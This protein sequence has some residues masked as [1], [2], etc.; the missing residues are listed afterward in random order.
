M[1]EQRPGES[2]DTGSPL[3]GVAQTWEWLANAE[4]AETQAPDAGASAVG[5]PDAGDDSSRGGPVG[6]E[7]ALEDDGG[8]SG[9]AGQNPESSEERESWVCRTCG[10]V[11]NQQGGRF[12]HPTW[13][14]DADHP[15][16]PV[17]LADHPA[18]VLACDFCGASPVVATISCS[19]LRYGGAKG[20][21]AGQL[22]AVL[23]GGMDSD[24]GCC[25]VCARLL[26]KNRWEQ[27]TKRS[28]M[29]IASRDDGVIDAQ[30]TE[31]IRML[32]HAIR[33][34]A[35]TGVIYDKDR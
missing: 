30:M 5:A 14:T 1:D 19:P 10:R 31:A 29:A 15:V 27:V 25:V 22:E 16:D 26:R 8:T 24:W 18:P 28:V 4:A 7:H 9:A 6:Q 13:G 20:T 23:M 12:I 32:H 2:S 33:D 17:P 21:A 3:L 34:N 11:L 35:T